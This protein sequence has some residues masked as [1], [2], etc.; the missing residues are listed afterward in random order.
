M[1]YA[2]ASILENVRARLLT[3][4]KCYWSDIDLE[5]KYR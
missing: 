3:M 4:R 5:S 1:A 2:A